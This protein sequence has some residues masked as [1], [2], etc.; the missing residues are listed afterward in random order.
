VAANLGLGDDE[1]SGQLAMGFELALGGICASTLSV[2]SNG[3]IFFGTDGATDW[4]P[5]EIEFVDGETRLAAYW[6]D[7][8]PNLGGTIHV[9]MSPGLAI[10]TYL[11]VFAFGSI[12][13]E[14]TM[15]I[16][17]TPSSIRI[18]YDALGGGYSMA[19]IV[20][21]TNGIFPGVIPGSSDLSA[22]PVGPVAGSTDVR[23]STDGA[24]VI[25]GAP[26]R[27]TT[28]GIPAGG[29]GSTLVSLGPCLNPGLPLSGPLFGAGC[30][31]Y[32]GAGFVNLGVVIS[33]GCSSTIIF[34][35]IPANPAFYGLPLCFQSGA[36]SNAGVLTSNALTS[37][38]GV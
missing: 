24:P 5:T 8:A 18:I 38:A 34:G 19:P 16:R 29:L 3:N 35:P 32:V 33:T 4:S 22:G 30:V 11:N 23:L 12:A 10:V 15:Q 31:Q 14:V 26:M 27:L 9:D 20:G 6:A 2:G 25:G 17:I 28:T 37:V 13:P 7:L 36:F 21:L 1:V